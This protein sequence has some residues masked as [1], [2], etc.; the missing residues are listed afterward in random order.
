M[1]FECVDVMENV[2]RFLICESCG[3]L[4]G[5]INVGTWGKIF[6]LCKCGSGIG[7]KIKRVPSTVTEENKC[8]GGT[9]Y[10]CGD[11][12]ICP[13]CGNV[14]FR[15]DKSRIINCGFHIR[16][17]CGAEYTGAKRLEQS[18]RRLASRRLDADLLKRKEELDKKRKV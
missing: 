4:V 16:C 15:I 1:F 9:L 14:V 18:E 13:R 8:G 17:S 12:Y 6:C 11:N 7:R 10:I 3:K 2:G 5:Y